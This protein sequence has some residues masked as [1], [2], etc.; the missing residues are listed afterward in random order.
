MF[1]FKLAAFT[2]ALMAALTATGSAQQAT[3]AGVGA[4]LPDGKVA[5]INTQVFP[6]T[7]LE[8]KQKYEQVN[9]Q[10]KDRFQKL[11]A[12]AEQLK[13]MESDLRTKQNVLTADKY[14]ELQAGYTDLKKRGEREQEDF[15]ADADKALDAATKPIRDKMTQFLNGYAAKRNIVVLINLAGAAQSGSLAYW[16]PGLDI[17]EDFVSEYNKAN[18]VAGVTAAPPATQPAKPPVKPAGKP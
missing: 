6:G 10:F 9:N 2:A 5:V 12:M 4:A 11:Q 17:T 13:G 7:I 14:Q 15:N 18:P 3:Q 1:K 16:N 8:L